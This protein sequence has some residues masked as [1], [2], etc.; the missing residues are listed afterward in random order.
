[1]LIA[2]SAPTSSAAEATT[3]TSS[4]PR[5]ADGS[6]LT[7]QID[8]LSGQS[9]A[10]AT[11]NTVHL[12]VKSGGLTGEVHLHATG[13]QDFGGGQGPT[14]V[15]LFIDSTISTPVPA[16]T[17]ADSSVAVNGPIDAVVG[18]ANVACGS[19]PPSNTQDRPATLAV[20]VTNGTATGTI[21][22][23]DGSGTTMQLSAH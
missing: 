17:A 3:T 19:G 10:G 16:T 23:N 22:I 18:Y 12:L 21:A 1:M 2:C 11:V 7:G 20:T 4:A 9:V 5:V 8:S 13:K 6:D 14:D 15:C